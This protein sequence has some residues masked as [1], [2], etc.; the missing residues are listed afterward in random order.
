MVD[1]QQYKIKDVDSAQQVRMDCA[2]EA[3]LLLREYTDY[4]GIRFKNVKL[5]TQYAKLNFDVLHNFKTDFDNPEMKLL[6]SDEMVVVNIDL[7]P[8]SHIPLCALYRFECKVGTE[9]FCD[10][11]IMRKNKRDEIIRSCE[12]FRLNKN[13]IIRDYCM[14][15]KDDECC[16]TI[17]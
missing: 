15:N 10:G 3:Y 12:G 4:D 16:C 17:L 1:L 7:F 13:M 11:V 5:P 2:F 14:V 9:I 8:N 6:N